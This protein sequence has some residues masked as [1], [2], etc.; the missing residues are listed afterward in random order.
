M[1]KI[2][3]A[4]C[5]FF[6]TIMFSVPSITVYVHGSQNATKLL[7]KDI[8]YCKKGLHHI[9][10]LPK[11]SLFVQDAELLQ[12]G[13]PLLF[14]QDHYYTYG[15]SGKINF[16]VRKEAGQELYH[17]LKTLLE[18]YYQEHGAYPVVRIITNSH[19]GNVALN[20][21]QQLPF[22]ENSKIELELILLACPVQKATEHIVNHPQISRI[23]NLYSTFDLIQKLDFYKHNG[24]WYFPKRTFETIGTCNCNQVL[25]K[26]N[27]KRLSHT[28]FC[29]SIVRHIPEIIGAVDD[30]TVNDLCLLKYNIQDPDF[31]FYNGF[32]ISKAMKAS[33]KN[34]N[35]IT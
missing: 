18:K 25:V 30:A 22:F 17:A 15:W 29:H 11:S 10:E 31:V 16:S 33:R 12:K 34:K 26:V 4:V 20:M 32:N 3:G 14:N 13:N 28:D 9:N 1:R 8:W 19:G 7:S 27:G 24:R 5:L 21:A 23:Y 6:H 35:Q 2:L